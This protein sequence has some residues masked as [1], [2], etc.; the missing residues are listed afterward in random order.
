M[1]NKPLVSVIINCFNGDK[2]LHKALSSVVSQ[3]YKKWEII[4]WDNQ[5]IDK[6]SEI[7]K[8]YKDVR[9][10]YYYAPK[11]SKFFMKQETMQ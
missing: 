7:F 10:K 1:S 8:S 2:Y 9:F 3:T 11:H 5:S 4:F 6:S